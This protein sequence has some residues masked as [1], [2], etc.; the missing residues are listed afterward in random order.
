MTSWRPDNEQFDEQDHRPGLNQISFRF[1]PKA[2]LSDIFLELTRQLQEV[3]EI[4]RGL[5]AIRESGSTQF[6]ATA[7]FSQRKTRKNLSLRIPEES[8][9]FGKVAEQ[10]EIYADEFFDLFS[11]NSIEQKLLVDDDTRSYVVLPIKRDGEVVGLLGYS[12]ETPLAFA[13]LEQAGIER[14]TQPLADLIHRRDKVHAY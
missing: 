3:F 8:S 10:R 9:L 1:D 4:N 7:T 5:L 13:A 14:L 11:G 2:G 6:L 12:S